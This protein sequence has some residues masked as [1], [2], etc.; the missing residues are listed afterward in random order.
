[1]NTN[2]IG[3]NIVLVFLALLLLAGAFSGGVLVGWLIPNQT[4]LEA[5]TL[6]ATPTPAGESQGGTPESLTNLFSPFWEAWQLVHEQFVDQ[7]V[8]D[9]KLMQGAI[10]GMLDSLGDVHS[11]YMTPQEY[12]Q[13]TMPLDGSYEGIGAWV[14]STGK[15]LT[16]I[17][18]MPN[19]PAETA[20]LKAGDEI[21]KIDGKDIT[22]L[23][24]AVVLQS[25][26]GP[27]GSEVTLTIQRSDP[28]EI[29]DFTMKRAKIDLP[30]IGS[31]MLDKKIAYISLSTFGD[32]TTEDLK[33]ALTTQLAENPVG[34]I[35][36]LRDNGGGYLNTAIEVISQFIPDGVVMIEQQGN[37]QEITYNA[38]PGGLATTIPLVVLVNGGSASASEITAGAIQ[39][40]GRG[41]LVGVTT[42]GKGSVQNW[43][44]LV[45]DQGAIRVT[46]ARWLTPNRRQINGVGLT[47]DYV[48]EISD[49][50]IAAKVDPQLQ[51]AID[52]L[53]APS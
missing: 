1:M 31:E 39:D 44:P 50:D 2:H 6:S 4:A 26:L 13:A 29:L 53:L 34:L 15:L 45:D 48:V 8:D 18:P 11:G 32:T 17:S 28:V 41:K 43:I 24:P 21:I 46:I 3:R 42:Y 33:A 7:P 38:M 16:I 10:R 49:A 23:E 5:P 47:P 36:D 12:A 14:D 27:A 35:L 25:V 9:A 22:S 30:T 20:G 40:F 37:G 52:L 51:K 19:S